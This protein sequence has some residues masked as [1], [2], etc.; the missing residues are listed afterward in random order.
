MSS[1]VDIPHSKM[2]KIFPTVKNVDKNKLKITETGMFSVSKVSGSNKLIYLIKKYFKTNKLKITDATANVGSDTI[3]LALHF[4]HVNSIELDPFEFNVLKNNVDVYGLNNI[5]LFNDSSL[6][7]IKTLKQDVVYIDAPW[8][9]VDYKKNKSVQLFL[10]DKE[11]SNVYNKN[12]QYAKLFVFKV[13]KNYDF[14]FF[15]QNTKNTK[16]YLHSYVNH[17]NEIKYYFI[18]CPSS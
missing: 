17:K 14:N 6:D 12:K 8:G 16:Y 15:I 2:D 4:K 11:I 13:P 7:I 3:N 1:I 5:T 10:G 9:G 18:F